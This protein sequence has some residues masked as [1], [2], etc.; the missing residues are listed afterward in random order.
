MGGL[1][2]A[3]LCDGSKISAD[4]ARRLACIAG[5]IPVVLGGP[6]EPL[7]VGRQRRFHTKPMRI[8]MGL[9]DGGCTTEG[10]DRPPAWCQAHHDLSWGTGGDTNLATGRLLCQRHHTLAHDT[11]YQTTSAPNGKVAFTRRT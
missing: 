7:D 4:E 3:G 2:A 1:Q 11:R 5:I 9:R 8:A 6:S 10:C